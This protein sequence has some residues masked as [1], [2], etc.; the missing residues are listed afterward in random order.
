MEEDGVHPMNWTAIDFETAN[1]SRNSACALGVVSVEGERIVDATS[2]LIR[3]P[4]LDFDPFNVRIHG[5]T[6]E[7]V[8]D[9]PTFD[10][11]WREVAPLLAG[12]PVIAHNASFDISVLR[13]SLDA[14]EIPYP[15]LDYYCTLKF[16]RATWPGQAA[17]RLGV[18]AEQLG[19]RFRHHDAQEDAA[20]C[21]RIA[22]ECCRTTGVCD[23]ETLAARHRVTKGR[24]YPGGYVPCSGRRTSEP[25][26]N[27]S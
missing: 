13:H 12:A 24:L 19:I 9:S 14:Y 5:I 6:V 16:S 15:E 4:V 26:R 3:P 7:D 11:L 21:A 17:Y 18:L 8:R 10:D 2:W 25:E 27:C 22:L 1:A 20:A 23:L